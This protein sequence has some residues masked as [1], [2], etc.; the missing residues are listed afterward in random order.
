M[1]SA[2]QQI[3]SHQIAEDLKEIE[4]VYTSRTFLS[5]LFLGSNIPKN[6]EGIRVYNDAKEIDMRIETT[7]NYYDNPDSYDFEHFPDILE[8]E[9]GRIRYQGTYSYEEAVKLEENFK[10]LT[11]HFTGN[12]G[13]F[14]DNVLAAH[15]DSTSYSKIAEH[16]EMPLKH[17]HWLFERCLSYVVHAN[18][19]MMVDAAI[20]GGLKNSPISQRMLDCYRLG[21]MPGGWV[22]P[23]PK[24][25][26]LA[27]DCMELY[28]LGS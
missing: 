23:L 12:F 28:H 7:G 2:I 17:V 6:I 25:G 4:A 11:S 24:D 26:G 16:A 19:I 5:G 18:F 14:V 21:G 13:K 27:R 1:L 9:T 20:L 10:A 15:I 3:D 22:G 8:D